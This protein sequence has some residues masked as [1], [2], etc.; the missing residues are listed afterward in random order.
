LT[1]PVFFA[2]KHQH[3]ITHDLDNH[4]TKRLR[5]EARP[6]RL[7]PLIVVS[8]CTEI[9]LV[10][11]PPLDH[12]FR[13]GSDIHATGAAI[14]DAIDPRLLFGPRENSCYY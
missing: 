2:L 5:T 7:K 9:P 12:G 8:A 1:L 14:H 13:G 6:V 4:E 10:F 3:R 11:V